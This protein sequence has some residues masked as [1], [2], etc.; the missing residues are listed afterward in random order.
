M[1]NNNGSSHTHPNDLAREGQRIQELVEKIGTLHDPDA[2]GLLQECLESV[3]S[4]YGRGLERI[5][6]LIEKA[7]PDGEKLHDALIHD[8]GVRA[9]GRATDTGGRRPA[10][11]LRP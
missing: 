5:L 9:L 10:E 4:F 1:S 8:P 6:E 7:G 11:T 3:L 2:R